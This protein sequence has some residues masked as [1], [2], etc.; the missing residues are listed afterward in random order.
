[1]EVRPGL[2]DGLMTN[3]VFLTPAP[4][5]LLESHGQ[6]LIALIPN[7]VI[8]E[9][10]RDREEQLQHVLQSVQQRGGQC[11][12]TP[13]TP[14]DEQCHAIALQWSDET[15]PHRL[16]SDCQ[17]LSRDEVPA[18]GGELV[19]L[20]MQQKPYLQQ[21]G[22]GCGTVL[23]LIGIQYCSAPSMPREPSFEAVAE[24]FRQSASNCSTGETLLRSQFVASFL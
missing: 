4:V 7:H 18:Q 3:K 16:D 13:W 8:C 1:M 5:R 14:H 9:L 6:S 12:P 21:D 20:A 24:L 23:R 15:R 10:Q 11:L 19:R 22:M 2:D 17:P